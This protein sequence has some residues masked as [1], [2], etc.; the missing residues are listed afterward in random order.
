VQQ[1]LAQAGVD[2]KQALLFDGSGLSIDNRLS[3]DALMRLLRYMHRHP[4]A[5]AFRKSMAIAGRDGTLRWR[6]GE[7]ELEGRVLGKTGTMQGVRTVA[8][9][10]DTPGGHSLAYVVFANKVRSSRAV[11]DFQDRLLRAIVRAADGA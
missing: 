7:T 11:R 8:G 10:I 6:F 2:P 1:F 5:E 4:E 3:A 9:Y